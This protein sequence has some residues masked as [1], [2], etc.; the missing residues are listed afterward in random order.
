MKGKKDNT[1]GKPHKSMVIM[2]IAV[3]L[4]ASLWATPMQA[5]ASMKAFKDVRIRDS[6][7]NIFKSWGQPK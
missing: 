4:T 6:N 1:K 2:M 7:S 3:L 5:V